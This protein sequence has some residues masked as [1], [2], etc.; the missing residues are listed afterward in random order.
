MNHRLLTLVTALVIASLP[1]GGV[2]EVAGD[3]SGLEQARQREI[4]GGGSSPSDRQVER[5]V[6][7]V[8]LPAG[9]VTGIVYLLRGRPFS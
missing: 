8:V 7:L 9:F 2:A 1:S 5:F 4:V 6:E 3:A